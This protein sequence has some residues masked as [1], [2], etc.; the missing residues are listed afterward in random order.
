[1][2]LLEARKELLDFVHLILKSSMDLLDGA[3]R[4]S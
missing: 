4:V 3:R 1:M 2:P